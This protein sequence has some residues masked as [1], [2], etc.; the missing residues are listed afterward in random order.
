MATK[1]KHVTYLNA[2][3]APHTWRTL[4]AQGFKPYNFG[5]SAVFPALDSAAARSATSSRAIC[6]NATCCWRI[7]AL[8][9]VSLVCEKDG[10]V[11]AFRLQA[12]PAGSAAVPDDGLD[13]L[14]RHGDFVA[15]PAGAGTPSSCGSG[16]F[17]FVIDGKIAGLPSHLCRRQ[18]A[19]LSTRAPKRRV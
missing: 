1:L 18:G 13:L 19:A 9:C 8:G 12:A 15:L 2:S 16:V 6:R 10:A 7:A 5:R 3:P 4:Q 11:L 14:P 17:G